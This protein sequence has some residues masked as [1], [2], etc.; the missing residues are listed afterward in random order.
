MRSA[1]ESAV[2]AGE[3]AWEGDDAGDDEGPVRV[4]RGDGGGGI[5]GMGHAVGEE[6]RL[7]RR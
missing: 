1:Q 6:G 7:R 4:C 5:E 2:I 3:E